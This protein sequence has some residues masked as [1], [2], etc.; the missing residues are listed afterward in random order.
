MEA[1]AKNSTNVEEAFFSMASQILQHFKLQ[2]SLSPNNNPH[3]TQ[4]PGLVITN[5]QRVDAPGEGYSCC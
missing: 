3:Q 1:S 5:A 2:K 4:T